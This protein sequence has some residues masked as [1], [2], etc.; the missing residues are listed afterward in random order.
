MVMTA[1]KIA[2]E[3]RDSGASRPFWRGLRHVECIFAFRGDVGRDSAD[4]E[5]R[6]GL[7]PLD[8]NLQHQAHAAGQ[9]DGVA[10]SHLAKALRQTVSIWARNA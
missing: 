3:K 9:N 5:N 10:F 2:G 1:M 4:P 7:W 8:M 6:P